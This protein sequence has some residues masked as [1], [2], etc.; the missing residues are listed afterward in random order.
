[1]MHGVFGTYHTHIISYSFDA[2]QT[3]LMHREMDTPNCHLWHYTLPKFENDK[4]FVNTDECIFITEGVIL[5]DKE[6]LEQYHHT[7]LVSLIPHLY[8]SLG[9]TFFRVFRGSFCGVVYDI[10]QDLL[11][12]YN[13][14]IG[15]HLIFYAEA[16]NGFC[17]SSDLQVLSNALRQIKPL[18]HN[19]GFMYSLLTYGYSPLCETIYE[20]I[21]RIPAGKYLRITPN[22]HQLLTFHRF[23]NLP[24]TLSEQ[25][26]IE[27]MDSL[28]RNAVQRVIDKN[29]QYHF[30][31]YLPLSAGLDSRMT[32]CVAHHLSHEPIHNVTY[33]QSDYYDELIPKQLADYW[34]NEM[35]F[36]ALDGGNYL[37]NLDETVALTQGLVQY[38]GASQVL[39]SFA[40]LPKEQIG[41]VMTGML[42]DIIFGTAFTELNYNQSYA[43]GCGAYSQYHIDRLQNYIPSDFWKE[44]PNRE[45]YYLYVRGCYCANLGSPLILQSLGES[46]S[47]FYDVDVLEFALSIPLKWRWDYHIYDKWILEKYPD[48]AQWKHNGNYTIGKRPKQVSLC[49][50][51]MERKD[52]PKRLTWYILKK[53][54]IHDYYKEQV[55]ASMNPEDF[56]FEN[57]PYLQNFANTYF[58][59]NMPLLAPEPLLEA[60]VRDLIHKNASQKMQSLTLLAT[61]KHFPC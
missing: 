51:S 45:I 2:L 48:M 28:F 32:N 39:D 54:H 21:W 38:S 16:E 14:H 6:L 8:Q 29:K 19:K 12:V 53:M 49:G 15:D 18:Q 13:D 52:I 43:L 33:S 44:Y 26:N 23:K 30:T 56:W 3:N 4:V 42:G 9:E 10:K 46:Y 5:N 37:D 34:G 31:N 25:E 58:A 50:R 7:S 60:D 1:M 57:N 55:G 27:H 35:H 24:N 47:P 22:A 61:L 20:G 17:F 59:E 40:R 36:R 41:I 11:L